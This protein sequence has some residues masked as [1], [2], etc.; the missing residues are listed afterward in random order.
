MFYCKYSST[1]MYINFAWFELLSKLLFIIHP[2]QAD[3]FI[4]VCKMMYKNL[5]NILITIH[6]HAFLCFQLKLQVLK[7]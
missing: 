3:N 4:I 5:F 1:G 2:V 6:L 7:K